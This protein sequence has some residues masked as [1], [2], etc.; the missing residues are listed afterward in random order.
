MRAHIEDQQTGRI[1]RW[2]IR[3]PIGSIPELKRTIYGYLR[4]TTPEPTFAGEADVAYLFT[5]EH[6]AHHVAR[7]LGG[8]CEVCPLYLEMGDPVGGDNKPTIEIAKE[9]PPSPLR[10]A[11]ADHS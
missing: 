10:M 9:M 7:A 3:A 1:V 2:V 5:Q 8:Q 11:T 6:W 4:T